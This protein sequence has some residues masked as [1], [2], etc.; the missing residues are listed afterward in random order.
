MDGNI[1]FPD[2]DQDIFH[3]DGNRENWMEIQFGR[4]NEVR[5]CCPVAMTIYGGLA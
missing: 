4:R 3:F 1:N 5:D 2:I